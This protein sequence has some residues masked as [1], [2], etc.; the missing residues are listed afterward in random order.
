MSLSQMYLCIQGTLTVSAPPEFE[1][2]GPDIL[3]QLASKYAVDVTDSQLEIEMVPRPGSSPRTSASIRERR[4]SRSIRSSPT[5]GRVVGFVRTVVRSE[6]FFF[7][8]DMHRKEGSLGRFRFPSWWRRP[9]PTGSRPRPTD[10]GRRSR[11]S[12]LEPPPFSAP[13]LRRSPACPRPESP[14]RTRQLVGDGVHR[15][16]RP[17]LLGRATPLQREPGP[18][19]GVA[20]N[21]LGSV[22]VTSTAGPVAIDVNS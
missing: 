20:G 6:H 2:G 21:G 11:L 13:L 14:R 10:F 8:V 18:I 16:E 17:L 15:L 9:T 1:P 7:A 12:P 4:S 19:T 5:S 22:H 3:Q